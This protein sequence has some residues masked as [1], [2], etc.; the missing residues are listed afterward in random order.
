LLTKG[1]LIVD[2]EELI[3]KSLRRILRREGFDTVIS[4]LSAEQGIK[5][6]EDTRNQ[7][8]LI[9]S[10]QRM[11]GMSGSEFLEKSIVEKADERI[12]GIFEEQD[13]AQT[14]IGEC[15][16]KIETFITG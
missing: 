12:Q 11:P 14:K 10:D 4:A 9:I 1:I 7:F 2:D 8:F 15:E 5:L 16:K 6:L 3:V 13:S